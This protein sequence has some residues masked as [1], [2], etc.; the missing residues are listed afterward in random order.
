MFIIAIV[1]GICIKNTM[2]GEVKIMRDKKHIKI[3][4]AI[5]AFY[6]IVILVTQYIPEINGYKNNL[7]DSYIQVSIH[8]KDG[9]LEEYQGKYFR[10]VHR[11]DKVMVKIRLPEQY[12][13]PEAALCFRIYNSIISVKYKEKELYRYGDEIAAKGRQI[14]SVFA[15]VLVPDEAFGDEITIECEVMENRAYSQIYNVTLLP[16]AESLKYT[17]TNRLPNFL[18]FITILIMSSLV[19]FILILMKHKDKNI[20]MAILLALF[21]SMFSTYIMAY[22]GMLTVISSNHKFNADIEYIMLFFMQVPLIW[23]F[24][25]LVEEKDLNRVL[26]VMG[27]FS[28]VFAVI[29]TIL[30]YKTINYHYCRM[31]PILHILMGIQLFILVGVCLKEKNSRY[32]TQTLAINGILVFLGFMVVEIIR[33]NLDKYLGIHLNITFLP[34]AVIVL[35]TMLVLENIEHVM[36]SYEIEKEKEHLEKLAYLDSLTGLVNRTRCQAFLDELHSEGIHE[37]AIVFMDLNNLKVANDQFGHAAGDQYIKTAASIFQKYFREADICGRMGGDEFIV[38]Y[39]G[40]FKGKL[41]LLISNINREFDEINEKGRFGF[42]MSV[43]CGSIR[44]TKEHPIEV[45]QAIA[46]A[47]KKMYENKLIIKKK[48]SM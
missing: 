40:R 41:H 23:Y 19:F 21:S 29:C 38:I 46:I 8:R 6:M 32:H 33:F 47:D 27:L 13:F 39:K 25:E 15:S 37:Y 20:R 42:K 48:L 7:L 3:I 31:I 36:E 12:R 26:K 1:K 18:V 30:N 45:E 10:L 24:K 14:G 44:S 43:A 2:T 16:S 5:C 22:H 28:L 35:I 34:I 9:S 4:L 17:I 11:G